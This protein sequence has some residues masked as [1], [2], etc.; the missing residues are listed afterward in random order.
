M[1]SELRHP[2]L[3]GL[4][5]GGDARGA[6]S[7]VGSSVSR[8]WNESDPK[9]ESVLVGLPLGW[10]AQQGWD[11]ATKAFIRKL[12]VP[13]GRN[14]RNGVCLEPET[15]DRKQGASLG[16]VAQKLR[17]MILISVEGKRPS[18]LTGSWVR[19]HIFFQAGEVGY[20]P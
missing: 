16:K 6:R 9:G 19:E 5:S 11:L 14:A 12:C 18:T 4:S 17:R 7:S 10:S 15:F 20:F 2:C 3:G 8:A 1:D 13:L